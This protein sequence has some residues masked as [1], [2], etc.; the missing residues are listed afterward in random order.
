MYI[1]L[2]K[3]CTYVRRVPFSSKSHLKSSQYY[4][5]SLFFTTW[6]V[7]V[8]SL[9][10]F[11]QLSKNKN[12]M[13]GYISVRVC[14]SACMCMCMSM[15]LCEYSRYTVQFHYQIPNA[16]TVR[17]TKYC[18]YK[19]KHLILII[20][21]HE[22]TLYLVHDINR[23]SLWVGVLENQFQRES[24]GSEVGTR[25]KQTV[26]FSSVQFSLVQFSSVPVRSKLVSKHSW[27]PLPRLLESSPDENSSNVGLINSGYILSGQ[28][29][30]Q[31]L[32]IILIYTTSIFY[33]SKRK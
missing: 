1:T 28:S 15:S 7:S 25:L 2:K 22:N 16:D 14:V 33:L 3:Y 27:K 6:F 12:Y 20:L 17:K 10:S 19:Y 8:T 21:K 23:V 26:Q 29:M 18:M 32:M 30:S 9:H 11:S 24:I 13:N 5:P 4:R 31:K